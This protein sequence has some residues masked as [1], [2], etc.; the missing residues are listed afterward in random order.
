MESPE[1]SQGQAVALKA[2]SSKANLSQERK[3]QKK[4]ARQQATSPKQGKDFFWKQKE[5]TAKCQRQSGEGS[6]KI[7]AVMEKMPEK[8]TLR[9]KQTKKFSRFF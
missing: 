9:L 7:W 3:N 2:Q 8:K 4:E 6:R 5:L 1:K